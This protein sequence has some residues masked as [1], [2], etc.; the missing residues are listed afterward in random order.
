MFIFGHV[1]ITSALVVKLG[2]A[3]SFSNRIHLQ[4]IHFPILALCSIAPDFIDKPLGLLYPGF[5]GNRTRL[6]AHN[7][8][9]CVIVV[10]MGYFFRKKQNTWVYVFAYLGHM[11][12]DRL[13]LDQELAV[14]FYPF[15]GLPTRIEIHAIDRWKGMWHDPYTM[16]GEIVGFFS[17]L[18]VMKNYEKIKKK[19]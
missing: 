3:K 4:K 19:H 1:G 13:W 17:L 16:I 8:F 5:F 6:A 11:I 7:W 12:F 18:W 15:L 10:L 9:A 2:K 14:F